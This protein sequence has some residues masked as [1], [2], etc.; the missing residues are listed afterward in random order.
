LR[1]G[2][3]LLLFQGFPVCGSISVCHA[4]AVAPSLLKPDVRISRIRLS[5]GRFAERHASRTSRL[6]CSAESSPPEKEW[7]SHNGSKLQVDPFL[8]ANTCPWQEP[9]TRPTLL[10]VLTTM[11][12]S[13]S[14]PGQTAVIDS[15]HPLIRRH[16][17]A[18]SP[19]WVS[20]VDGNVFRD[21]SF[22]NRC[23]QPPR[24][25]RLLHMLVLQKRRQA[26]PSLA[27]WPFPNA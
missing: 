3:G 11:A 27:G 20:Q 12:P 21:R 15:R 14:Q 6:G 13:D 16:V 22:R 7:L 23:P 19:G 9:F 10:G 4:R 17:A 1:L 24:G 2:S 5:Q 8:F 18:G 26:S 25:T